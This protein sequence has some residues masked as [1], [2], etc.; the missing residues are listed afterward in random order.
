MMNIPVS[1]TAL[2]T[3]L[4]QVAFHPTF[5]NVFDPIITRI[6]TSLHNSLFATWIPAVL[7]L[8]GIAILIRARRHA[9]AT[10][11]GAIGWAL[12]VILLATALFRWPIAAGHI[13]DQTVTSTLGGVV[14]SID[15]NNRNIDPGT[16]VASNVEESIFYKSWLAGTLGSTDSKTAK[17]YGPQLFKAQALTWRQ[18]YIVEHNPARGRQIINTK[19]Q[20]WSNVAAQV[21]AT[22]PMAYEFLTGHRSDTRVG[23]AVLATVGALLAVPFLLV[24]ALLLLGSFMI[25]RLAVMLFPAFATLGVFPSARGIVVGLGRTVGAALVNSVIFGIGAAVTVRVLGLILDPAS[26]LPGWLSLVLMP[27]FSVIMWVA[28]KPFRRLTTMV[29]SHADPFG[30]GVGSFGRAGHHASRW[31]KKAATTAAAVYTGDMA[32]AATVAAAS[33]DDEN[34]AEQA[35]DR[36]EARPTPVEPNLAV[37][38]RPAPKEL[39][40]ASVP[41]APVTDGSSTPPPRPASPSESPGWR[42]PEALPEGFVPKPTSEGVP[43]PPTEPEWQDGEEVYAIYRPS[44]EGFGDDAA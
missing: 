35:P 26:R 18:A 5:L 22:D 33:K 43:L 10:T 2:T 29:S 12:M 30:E 9:L 23:Y 8:L 27:L 31:A 34:T 41:S 6:S 4:T 3:S 7:A 38:G 32:A 11:A 25:V 28:L 36:A 42:P 13:A 19:E 17:R 16:S 20:Q 24:A 15:G 37:A 14:N 39:P 40:T 1:V 21:K 44:D